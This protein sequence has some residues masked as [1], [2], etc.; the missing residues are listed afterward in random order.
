M[1]DTLDDEFLKEILRLNLRRL[2]WRIQYYE[3]R[4]IKN[5]ICLIE[6][7]VGTEDSIKEKISISILSRFFE[8]C[9]IRRATLFIAPLFKGTQKEKWQ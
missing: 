7:L 1:E 2:A 3:R 5:E 6:E 8:K 4:R 9:Q